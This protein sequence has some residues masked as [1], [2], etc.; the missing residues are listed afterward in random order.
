LAEICRRWIG[1]ADT[2]L[3]LHNAALGRNLTAALA[4]AEAA[5]STGTLVVSHHHDFFFDNRW[6]LWPEIQACG[7]PTPALAAEA[8]LAAG[9]RAVH[10]AINRV[11][12]VGLESGFGERAVWIP[13]AV[14]FPEHQNIASHGD[15]FWILPTRL[16]RR[17]NVLEA[18]LL[19]RWLRPEGRLV[20]SGGPGSANEAPYAARIAEAAKRHR[21]NVNLSESGDAL[22]ASARMASAECVLMTSLQE[23]FG[24]PYV[25]AALAQ[26]P[27]L[28]RRLSNVEPDL[29][30]L[31]LDS[32]NLYED[33]IVSPDLFRADLERDRQLSVWSEWRSGLPQ[34]LQSL[35]G[36]PIFCSKPDAPVAFSRLTFDAQEEILARSSEDLYS[37]LAP[38]NSGLASVVLQPT[39]LDE[40]AR[41]AFSP[42]RFAMRFHEA[43]AL[44]DS[45]PP[46]SD[47]APRRALDFFLSE[48]L[49][50]RNQ[51]PILFSTAV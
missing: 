42:E 30:S 2:V 3:W 47:D 48:R 5:K 45:A 37:A 41:D 49:A 33:V 14:N 26:R 21:W 9:L 31:G 15:D 19:T 46:P 16:L 34:E 10:V 27:L 44:A 6:H 18:V 4:W 38:L 17:K 39:D 51:Y 29:V 35:C 1:N 12:F 8:A 36:E 23:G 28:G 7:F 32:P 43:V 22:P 20:I 11:D 13:N 24:L 50:S 40:M 25:E